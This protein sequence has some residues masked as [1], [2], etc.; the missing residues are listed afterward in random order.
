MRLT[1]EMT[2]GLLTNKWWILRTFLVSFSLKKSVAVLSVCARLHSFCLLLDD[3]KKKELANG[4]EFLT[5][6]L[7]LVDP[8]PNAPLGWA[9]LPTVRKLD[10][11]QGTSQIR[12]IILEVVTNNAFW[13]PPANVL[14]RQRELTEIGLM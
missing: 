10:V 14:R 11:V 9:Y 3:D 1:Y 13:R 12:Q 2:F 4:M 7:E 5:T 8:M 6:S